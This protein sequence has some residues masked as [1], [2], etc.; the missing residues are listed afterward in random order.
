MPGPVR[1]NPYAPPSSPTS[2]YTFG[3]AE[4]TYIETRAK[5]FGLDPKAVLAVA[6]V[7][8]GSL[9]AHVGDQG[10]SFGPWQLHAGGQLPAEVWA[11]GPAYAKSWAD[12]PAGIDYA[13]AGIAKVARNQQGQEAIG[14]IVGQFERPA[15]SAAEVQRAISIYQQG[16]GPS[17]GTGSAFGGVT[18]AVGDATGA[19]T[20]AVGDVLHPFQS[21]GDVFTFLTSWRFAEVLGGFALL[22]VGLVLL[23]KQ[24]GIS[25]PAAIPV[26]V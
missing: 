12:S 3:P 22:L 13:L 21:I 24:F 6:A 19:V 7:E 11:K 9:P 5:T 23:G 17:T 25:P 20:G 4:L 16:G 2:P 15:N 10:T 8:G 18:G 26:P 1:P 14:S